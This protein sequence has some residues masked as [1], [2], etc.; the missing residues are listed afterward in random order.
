MNSAPSWYRSSASSPTAIPPPRRSTRHQARDAVSK[1]KPY[2]ARRP[3]RP[4]PIPSTR[5]ISNSR[6]HVLSPDMTTPPP[7]DAVL[8]RMTRLHPKL[9]DLSLDRV[10]RL[11]ADL[12]NPQDKL[13]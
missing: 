10:R 3:I 11:L 4:C 12:D 2:R 9:I 8:E 7:V 6:S 13:P 1:L 5:T